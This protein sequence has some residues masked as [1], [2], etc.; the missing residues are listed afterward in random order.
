MY[1]CTLMNIF[2]T[3]DCLAWLEISSLSSWRFWAVI[4]VTSWWGTF[5]FVL[6]C[7]YSKLKRSLCL[8]LKS[9][10]KKS[11]FPKV[12]KIL[13]WKWNEWFSLDALRPA[14]T[15]C[16]KAHLHTKSGDFCHATQCSFCCAE[17][18]SSFKQ[19]QN[20]C[21][22]AAMFSPLVYTHANSWQFYGN[23]I[24]VI[25]QKTSCNFGMTKIALSCATEIACV[26]GPWESSWKILHWLS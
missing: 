15:R 13:F 14:P 1:W 8:Y 19:V 3:C 11:F 7:L 4:I 24:A 16:P 26:N 6:V 12:C 18:A 2:L 21:D 25:S 23:F 5:S 17:V 10:V 22:I 9:T 20:S